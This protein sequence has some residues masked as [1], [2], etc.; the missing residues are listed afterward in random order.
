M[1]VIDII[2]VN[3]TAVHL[4]VKFASGKQ[5]YFI[6][7]KE[8]MVYLRRSEHRLGADPYLELTVLEALPENPSLKQCYDV[9]AD[10]IQ[11]LEDACSSAVQPT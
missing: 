10:Y 3:P 4:Q 6:N 9:F 1:A 8:R 5:I 11:H 7:L 2:G